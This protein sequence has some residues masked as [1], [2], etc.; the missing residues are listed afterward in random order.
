[1]RRLFLLLS[2]MLLL[3]VPVA[4]NAQDDAPE[5]IFDLNNTFTV[6]DLQLEFFYPEGWLFDTSD[7][8]RLA[9]NEADLA[10]FV[11]DD[12]DTLPDGF[13]INLTAVPEEA[14]GVEDPTLDLAAEAIAILAEITVS[15]SVEV[16]VMTRRAISLIGTTPDGRSGIV[17]MWRQDGLIVLFSLGVGEGGVTEEIAYTWGVILGSMQS[18]PLAGYELTE[19]LD[20]TQFGVTVDYPTGWS[21]VE[22]PIGVFF[23]ELESDV[24]VAQT[25]E[26]AEGYA[27]IFQFGRASELGL[28]A[29]T[30]AYE[31]LPE[32]AASV[33]GELQDSR[34]IE[35]VVLDVPGIV[36]T[37]GID[38]QV[39]NVGLFVDIETDRVLLVAWSAP[40]AQAAVDFSST[41]L[42]MLQSLRLT[43]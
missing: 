24:D 39:G 31:Q 37:G 6:E 36:L 21:V 20:V 38:D 18:L 3:I 29:E 33:L 32:L 12:P 27:V 42:A 17:T 40:D 14:I 35:H 1:M 9:S 5:P 34:V 26:N 16:P 7:G 15:E 23:Y 25:G 22:D 28:T 30:F 13:T 8:I 11:D 2:L 10:A 43:E 4:V 19:T 41:A